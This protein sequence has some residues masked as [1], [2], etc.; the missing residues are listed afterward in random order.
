MH[1]PAQNS[2]SR[3]VRS[4]LYAGA[5]VESVE[6]LARA[7][8][9]LRAF[10][11][12]AASILR[13]KSVVFRENSPQRFVPPAPSD[14]QLWSALHK[15]GR[16]TGLQPVTVTA[17]AVD[18]MAVFL[19]FNYLPG[20]DGRRLDGRDGRENGNGQTAQ[21]LGLNFDNHLRALPDITIEQICPWIAPNQ[22]CSSAFKRIMT[23]ILSLNPQSDH[24]LKRPSRPLFNGTGTA[25]VRRVPSN[26]RNGHGRRP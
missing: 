8:P 10:F 13:L 16:G 3:L 9:N 12:H 14:E 23:K 15:P 17:T 6:T 4:C 24:L 22:K 20:R 7:F 1:G 11:K 26:R 21:T 5:G 19:G 25:P 18:S 2:P